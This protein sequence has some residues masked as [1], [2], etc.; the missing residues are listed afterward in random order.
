M[1]FPLEII[2]LYRTVI[3]RPT[4]ITTMDQQVMELI[5]CVLPFYYQ[6]YVWLSYLV[7]QK[8]GKQSQTIG[9]LVEQSFIYVCEE[10]GSSSTRGA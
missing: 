5:I 9:I 4:N 10:T 3:D 2:S 6:F 1:L 7:H 8:K